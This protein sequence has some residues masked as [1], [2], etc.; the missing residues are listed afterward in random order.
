[1]HTTYSPHTESVHKVHTRSPNTESL[2]TPDS[3][4]D[5]TLEKP[6]QKWEVSRNAETAEMRRRRNAELPASARNDLPA[7][8]AGSF[9]RAILLLFTSESFEDGVLHVEVNVCTVDVVIA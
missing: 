7:S 1:M 3:Y 9:L 6:Q 8:S 4:R 2:H 5:P